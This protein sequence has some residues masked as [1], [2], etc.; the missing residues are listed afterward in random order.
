MRYGIVG[1]GPIHRNHA[2]AARLVDGVELVGVVDVDDER[3]AAAA[4]EWDVPGYRTHA[5]LVA[6]GVD[7]VGVCVPH[8]LHVELCLDLAQA[9]VHVVC[10]KPLA[11]T[12]EDVDRIIEACEEHAVELAVVFQHRFNETSQLLRGLIARGA[13]GQLVLGTAVFQYH[14]SPADSAY[15]G[16][17]GSFEAAGGGALGNFGIHTVDLFCWLMGEVSE[18]H[19]CIGTV[20]MGTEVEDTAV[21]AV[22]FEN[23]A[24]GTVASTIASSPSYE[25]RIAISGTLGSA[26]MV[27]SRR[28]DVEYLDGRREQHVFEE[29]LDDPAFETKPAYGRGHI[30]V[31]DDFARALREG[32]TPVCSARSAR[33]THALVSAVYEQT[34]ADR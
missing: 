31:L 3:R 5:D 29:R 30:G 13:L 9:G 2:Q 34:L 33:R 18:A 14:K 19:G 21:V 23:G 28:L 4:R 8:S 22:R 32:G 10:E 12:L 25:S 27:D 17:R 1:C 11:T 20:T 26:V 16:W 24:F 15:F 7:A 6:A